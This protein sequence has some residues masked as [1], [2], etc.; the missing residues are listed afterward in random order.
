MLNMDTLYGII[1]KGQC[2]Y[3][4]EIHLT[5]IYVTHMHNCGVNE[6]R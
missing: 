4:S 2:E 3:T 6:K 1:G 5:E